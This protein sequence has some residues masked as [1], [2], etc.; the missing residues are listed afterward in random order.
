M[1][2]MRHDGV[3]LGDLW[4]HGEGIMDRIAWCGEGGEDKGLGG[5]AKV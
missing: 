2:L 1:L 5:G 4:E 3:S